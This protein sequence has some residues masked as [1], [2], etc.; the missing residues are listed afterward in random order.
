MPGPR[1]GNLLA[2]VRSIDVLMRN[3]NVN[4]IAQRALSVREV[5]KG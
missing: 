1:R 5:R 2:I 4:F 3:D